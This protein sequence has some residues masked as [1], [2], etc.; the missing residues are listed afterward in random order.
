MRLKSTF[1]SHLDFTEIKAENEASVEVSNVDWSSIEKMYPLITK[2]DQNDKSNNAKNRIGKDEM[3]ALILSIK[4]WNISNENSESGYLLKNVELPEYLCY[5]QIFIATNSLDNHSFIVAAYSKEILT[6][7][8]VNFNK[9]YSLLYGGSKLSHK[10]II[11]VTDYNEDNDFIYVFYKTNLTNFDFLSDFQDH[12]TEAFNDKTNFMILCQILGVLCHLSFNRIE[13]YKLQFTSIAIEKENFKFGI[14]VD[15]HLLYSKNFGADASHSVQSDIPNLSITLL[16]MIYSLISCNDISKESFGSRSEISNLFNKNLAA[17]EEN[18]EKDLI[19]TCLQY[20]EMKREDYNF[21]SLFNLIL[22]SEYFK[23]NRKFKDIFDL[24]P[25]FPQTFDFEQIQSQHIENEKTEKRESQSSKLLLKIDTKALKAESMKNQILELEQNQE[26]P[27]K[28]ENLLNK[29]LSKQKNKASKP[30]IVSS[31]GSGVVDNKPYHTSALLNLKAQSDSKTIFYKKKLVTPTI[32][33]LKRPQNSVVLEDT[34]TLETQENLQFNEKSRTCST[35]TVS[36]KDWKEER[37]STQYV[38]Q[39]QYNT[40][41][42]AKDIGEMDY[43]LFPNEKTQIS[44]NDILRR[45][46]INKSKIVIL[47]PTKDEN[48]ESN[49]PSSFSNLFGLFDVFKCGH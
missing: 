39:N 20:L 38:D 17:V 5:K 45:S 2:E 24:S 11:N 30:Q 29:V 44:A 34:F 49:S 41:L 10:N 40:T 36:Q 37:F 6:K 47:K 3:A 1:C 19:L 12:P 15:E 28:E 32:S 18:F 23:K 7:L 26:I 43:S 46:Y 31:N 14:L 33:K 35:N 22:N 48:L 42:A 9:V 27:S 16:L 8:K 21:V 13:P 4:N 25:C